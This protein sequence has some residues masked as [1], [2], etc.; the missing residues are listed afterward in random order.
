M[1]IPGLL[2]ANLGSKLVGSDIY[3]AG[4]IALVLLPIAYYK[5]N[6]LNVFCGLF[7]VF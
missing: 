7:F 6:I 3:Y 1:L 4:L 2:T 5:C